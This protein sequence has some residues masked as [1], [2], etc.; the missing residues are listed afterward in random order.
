MPLTTG[1]I[2]KDRYRIVKLL[3]QG[4]MGAVYRAWDINLSNAVA[5]KENL[6]SSAESQK[7]FM[8]EAQMLAR[9]THNNLPRVIDYFIVPG[10][11]QYLVMDYVEGEDLETKISNQGHLT[12]AQSLVW[13]NQVCDALNYLHNQPSPVIHR[14]IK[15][16]N[17]KIRPDGHAMLVDFG[18]AKVFDQHMKTTIGAKAVSPPY[19]P[20]EQYGGAL[21]DN[22]SDIYALGATLYH[23]LTG[24][25]P[26]E[27]ILRTVGTVRLIEPR[28]YNPEITPWTEQAIL[29]AMD[30]SPDRRFKTAEEFRSALVAPPAASAHEAYVAATVMAQSLQPQVA[31]TVMAQPMPPA[32]AQTVMAQPV[33]PSTSQ[34]VMPQ[35]VP[36]Q[37]Y[38]PPQKSTKRKP[39]II[40]LLV[41]AGL[42]LAAISCVGYLVLSGSSMGDEILTTFGFITPTAPVVVYATPELGE[43][44]WY[45]PAIDAGVNSIQFYESS[46]DGIPLDERSYSNSFPQSSTRFINWELNLQHPSPTDRIDFTIH[47]VYYSPDRSIFAEQDLDTYI[48]PEWTTST[49]FHGW[50]WDEPGNWSTGS[51]LI[52]LYVDNELIASANFDIY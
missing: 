23:M 38:N 22:R 51:Y 40:I 5:L 39:L 8:R 44:T 27:S 17:I 11:G 4:G 18:I 48:D 42:F 49:H 52:A 41:L 7:Q 33:P 24:Q 30:L 47:A 25:L 16:G 28:Q 31:Q 20:P 37:V 3:G 1:L 35:P 45:I 2:I 43:P 13:M 34:P 26:P 12:E 29:K 6:D 15:P 9:L 14:D 10:Q 50:G 21:T 36:P 32:V 19:S 46:V